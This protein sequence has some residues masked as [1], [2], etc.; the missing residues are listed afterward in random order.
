MK[1]AEAC[2]FTPEYGGTFI[3]NMTAL[4]DFIVAQDR[5]NEVIF[6]FPEAAASRTWC[7]ELQQHGRVLFCPSGY[8]AINRFFYRLCRDERIDVLHLHF[9]DIRSTVLVKPFTHTRVFYHAHSSMPPMGTKR[10]VLNRIKNVLC[11]PT[12]D[13][14][15]C[16]SPAVLESVLAIHYPAHKCATVINRVNFARFDTIT[17]SDPFHQKNATQPVQNLL[18]FGSYFHIKGIDIA[19]KALEPMVDENNIVLHILTNTPEKTWDE[20]V[21]VMG[22]RPAWVKIHHTTEHIADYYRTCSLFLAP[23]RTEGLSYAIIEALYCE[24][25]VVK[26]NIPALTYHIDN[27]EEITFDGTIDDLRTHI[28]HFL[29]MPP[30]TLA[31]KL[32]AWKQEVIGKYGITRWCEELYHLYTT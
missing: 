28:I 1:I 15:I 12:V 20:V 32:A 10:R 18:I 22:S 24:C 3:A 26:T 31:P 4:R 7:H 13:R 23:S 16:C 17:D 29:S 2:W 11:L 30:A 21:A 27:E 9:F 25:P 8:A 5:S 6:I 19:L 14:V